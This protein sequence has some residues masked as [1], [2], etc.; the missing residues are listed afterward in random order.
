[1]GTGAISQV[2]NSSAVRADFQ[3]RLLSVPQ[4][5]AYISV[6]ARTVWSWVYARKIPVIRIGG[7]VRI[8]LNELEKLLTAGTVPAIER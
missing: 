8:D 7:S 4:T 1:M 2:G 3:R 6:S 5:A